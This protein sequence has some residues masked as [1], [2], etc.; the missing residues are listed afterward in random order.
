MLLCALCLC[1]TLS[2]T[3]EECGRPAGTGS[4][5]FSTKVYS[6]TLKALTCYKEAADSAE[7]PSLASASYW[8]GAINVYATHQGYQECQGSVEYTQAVSGIEPAQAPAPDLPWLRVGQMFIRP[9]E[10]K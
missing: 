9:A 1:S 4:L 10:S 3:A 5:L 6:R 2:R 7:A 8:Q